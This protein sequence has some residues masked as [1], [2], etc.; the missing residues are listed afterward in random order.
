MRADAGVQAAF[1]PAAEVRDPRGGGS[2][3]R[4]VGNGVNV[5]PVNS[6][7]ANDRQAGE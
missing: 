2:V 5:D 1:P 7:R 4:E 3:A 6:M